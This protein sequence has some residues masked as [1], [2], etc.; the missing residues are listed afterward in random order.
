M[1][2]GLTINDW[3]S[4]S[5]TSRFEI[6]VYFEGVLQVYMIVDCFW[7]YL[8]PRLQQDLSIDLDTQHIRLS[9]SVI[10][11]IAKRNFSVDI[12]P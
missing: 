8:S 11:S 9:C 12:S 5:S 1:I 3:Y 10:S 4:F 7:I 2:I 6:Q